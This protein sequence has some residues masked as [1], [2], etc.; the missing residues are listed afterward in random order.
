MTSSERP[1]N[2]PDHYEGDPYLMIGSLMIYEFAELVES[3]GGSIR[4][5]AIEAEVDRRMAVR[6]LKA[7]GWTRPES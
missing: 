5:A 3:K 6:M 1:A 2:Y 4:G 7:L